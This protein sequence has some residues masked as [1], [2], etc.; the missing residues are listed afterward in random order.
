M[1][2][3]VYIHHHYTIGGFGFSKCINYSFQRARTH[4]FICLPH[5]CPVLL[6]LDCQSTHAMCTQRLSDNGHFDITFPSRAGMKQARVRVKVGKVRSEKSQTR[7]G[8]IRR[9]PLPHLLALLCS[10]D[11][12]G[13]SRDQSRKWSL[14][15]V[16]DE[17][18]I[19]AS[20]PNKLLFIFGSG[21]KAG[22]IPLG[23][24]LQPAE[25]FLCGGLCLRTEAASPSC[26]SKWYYPKGAQNS[27]DFFLR[28]LIAKGFF[29]LDKFSSKNINLMT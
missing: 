9:I 15:E 1:H 18:A 20:Q 28:I 6:L 12:I 13:Q 25:R 24:I 17:A 22:N 14:W 16:G 3:L 7:S 8:E 11:W 26:E 29:F 5:G 27:G 10:L 19:G 21:P 4:S 23:F 2:F